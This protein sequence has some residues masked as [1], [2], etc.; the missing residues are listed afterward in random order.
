[1][2][3]LDLYTVKLNVLKA[4]V[5][6]HNRVL[7]LLISAP[8][9]L[10]LPLSPSLLISLLI[11]APLSLSPHFSPSLLISAPLSLSA[12]V[13]CVCGP[14]GAGPVSAGT[15]SPP[16]AQPGARAGP[17]NTVVAMAPSPLI[18]L[19]DSSAALLKQR[20]FNTSSTATN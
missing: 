19:S 2:H 17:G 11:S 1:M 8:L 15:A 4:G 7:P 10:S 5:C 16:A 20:C 12:D 6:V 18:S 3:L 13:G 14:C 9:S